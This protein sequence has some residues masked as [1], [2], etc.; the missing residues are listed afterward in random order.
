MYCQGEKEQARCLKKYQQRD[1]NP[2][3]LVYPSFAGNLKCKVNNLTQAQLQ[4]N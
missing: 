4:G 1:G 2:S 3:L